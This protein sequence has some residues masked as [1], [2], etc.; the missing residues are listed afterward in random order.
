MGAAQQAEQDGKGNESQEKLR[1]DKYADGSILC[2]KFCGTIDE[3]F[4]GKK[5]ASTA[6]AKTLLLDLGEV[7]KI[8]S[9]GIREWVDFVGAVAKNAEDLILLQCSPKVVDQLNMVANFSGEKGRVYSF[10]CPYTCDYCD[11]NNKVVMQID[12]DHD[13][14]KALKPPERVCDQCGEPEYFDEDPATYFSFILGQEPFE[15]EYEVEA[16]LATKLDYA[17]SDVARKLRIDK[18]IEGRMIYIKLAGDLDGAFPK[19]KLAEGLEGTVVLDVSGVGR[20]DPAGAAEWRGAINIATATSEA[21]Y[22]EGVP[23]AFLEKLTGPEDLGPKAK[24]LSFTL[25]YQN[26][27]DGMTQTHLIDVEENYEVIKFATPPEIKDSVCIASESMLSFLPKLPPLEVSKDLRKFIKEMKERKPEKKSKATTVPKPLPIRAR[28]PDWEPCLPAA[29]L[30]R[31]WPSVACLA[32]TSTRRG[33]RRRSSPSTPRSPSR[34][35]PAPRSDQRG[36]PA[37]PASPRTAPRRTVAC[38]VS[39]SLRMQIPRKT[40]EWRPRRAPSRPSSTR[41]A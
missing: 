17:V 35:T 7:N 9:F 13:A 20:I 39:A 23:P 25:P 1:I 8:S 33:S 30:P 11:T 37:T 6:K 41:L 4:D 28:L 31:P 29:S 24:V 32:T 3:D 15:L 38:R 26:E 16:F 36:H 18:A 19:E 21:I 5:L 2:L 27:K 34:S 40:H 10:Q 12:Q 14:I 22:L